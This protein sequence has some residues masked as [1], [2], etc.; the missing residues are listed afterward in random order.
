MRIH[1]DWPWSDDVVYYG[2]PL[3]A[4]VQTERWSYIIGARS[5]SWDPEFGYGHPPNSIDEFLG[6]LEDKPPFRVF[7]RHPQ[8][9][10]VCRARLEEGVTCPLLK[11]HESWTRH[12][13]WKQGWKQTNPKEEG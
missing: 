10:Y 5:Q 11:G 13:N 6:W 4:Y 9:E 7:T 1:V 2:A 3:R 8:P 12:W